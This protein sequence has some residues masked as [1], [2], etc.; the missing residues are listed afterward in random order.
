M[1]ISAGVMRLLL[2]TSVMGMALLAIFYLRQRRMPFDEFL[3]WGLLAI[4]V[5]VFG[6]F[7]VIYKHPGRPAWSRRY[8]ATARR[9]S[10][11]GRRRRTPFH[12]PKKWVTGR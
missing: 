10:T 3:A 9:R 11:I 7:W 6:P 1:L 8:N 5:P 4:F 12:L 2:G